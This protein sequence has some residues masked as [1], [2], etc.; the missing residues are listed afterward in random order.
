MPDPVSRDDAAAALREIWERWQPQVLEQ[1]QVLE[2]SVAALVGDGLPDEQRAEAEREAHKLAGS[3]GTFG[4]RSASDCAREIESTLH[5][6]ASPGPEQAPLLARLVASLRKEVEAGSDGA[7][8]APAPASRAN[9]EGPLLLIVEHER[10]LA[11]QLESEA[12]ARGMRT[13]T[14]GD[15]E[16]A[17]AILA[18]RRPAAA[19]VDL[20]VEGGPDTAYPLLSNLRDLDPPVPALVLTGEDAFGDRVEVARRGV[21]GVVDRSLGAM[22]A[23]EGVAALLERTGDAET[24]V[25]AVDDDPALLEA[26]A[27]LLE[28]E[29]L[30]VYSLADPQRFWE[31]LDETVP[32]LLLLDFDMP[33][34]TGPE[35]C[36]VVRSDPR[37]STLPVVFLTARQDPESVEEVFSAG[38]DDYLSKPIVEAELR[39]RIRNRLERVHLY[40]SL[41]ETDPL[42][43]VSNR[44]R[45]TQALEQF[46][47]LSD[48]F[49]QPFSLALLD[50]DRFKLVN[51]THGHAAGDAV[52]R[53]LGQLMVKTFR[54]EDSVGRWGGEEF[55]V[56][57]YGMARDDGV[58]RMTKLLEEFAA[59]EFAS[60]EGSFSTS[61]S[62]GVAQYPDDGTDTEALYRA[63]DQVLYYAKEAGR[64]RVL[65]VGWVPDHERPPRE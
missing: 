49:G 10:E 16:L 53:R 26:V 35:L 41:A 11:E 8:R 4:K 34:I 64:K 36:R 6:D 14:A 57:M 15:T 63:A 30:T 46:A 59:E 55:V 2:R 18:D 48:R 50:I 61:F 39:T 5:E 20:G 56:G 12:K 9:E 28:R 1:V 25:L 43:E 33:H 37:W 17:S 3:L 65:P 62:A 24:R 32:D 54:G 27:A 47:R 45:S 22:R 52:L 31:V 21:R 44:R 42:T 58:R 29:G 7:S 40:R 13:K 60:P 51:D 19:L 38:A 23:I